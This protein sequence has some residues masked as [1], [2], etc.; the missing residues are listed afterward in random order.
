MMSFPVKPS[1]LSFPFRP[2][3]AS[4]LAVP[5]SVSGLLVHSISGFG[6][7]QQPHPKYPQVLTAPVAI[8]RSRKA[9]KK[10]VVN[11][12]GKLLI[13]TIYRDKKIELYKQLN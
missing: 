10:E 13:H 1:I 6:P 5:I 9:P 4:V 12:R 8:P 2:Q 7:D 11:S 3:I